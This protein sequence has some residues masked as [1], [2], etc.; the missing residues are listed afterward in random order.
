MFA[1]HKSTLIDSLAASG[2]VEVGLHP[3]FLPGSTHGRDLK[4]VIAHVCELY[5]RARCFRSHS[6]LGWLPDH[7]GVLGARLR[8]ISRCLPVRGYADQTDARQRSRRRRF[9]AQQRNAVRG[10]PAPVR[11]ISSSRLPEATSTAAPARRVETCDDDRARAV[12][13]DRGC[14]DDAIAGFISDNT[15]GG[16]GS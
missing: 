10:G 2:A 7:G 3:N 5:P 8:Q 11:L 14:G 4:S 1:T 13:A 12:G 9:H 16:L 6:L 15:A